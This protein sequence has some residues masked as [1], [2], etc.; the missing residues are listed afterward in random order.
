MGL[1]FSICC[2]RH[3]FSTPSLPPWLQVKRLSTVRLSYGG[4]EAIYNAVSEMSSQGPT[5]PQSPVASTAQ[6]GSPLTSTAQDGSPVDSTAQ[7][8]SPVASTAQ[9]GSPVASTV[10]DGS[11]VA[12][13]VQD[14]SPVAS[15]VQDG[16]PVAST[17]QDSKAG[18]KSLSSSL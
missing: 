2:Q 7:D 17:A 18:I 12:S 13:T 3:C 1:S 4:I 6:D 11:P 8:G 9:D 16:S 10:Q 15:T 14:G 5:P